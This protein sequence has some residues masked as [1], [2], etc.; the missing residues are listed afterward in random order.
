MDIASMV[1]A[2]GQLKTNK[3]AL[4]A[5]PADLEGGDA[6]QLADSPNRKVHSSP[7]SSPKRIFPLRKSA[8]KPVAAA[9]RDDAD[10]RLGPIDGAVRKRPASSAAASGG[11]PPAKAPKLPEGWSTFSRTRQDGSTKGKVDTYWIAPCGRHFRSMK[12]VLA[13]ISALSKHAE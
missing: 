11:S 1:A 9:A 7:K 12:Q 4:E 3:K 10:E 6:E 8:A 5:E 13:K 2:V